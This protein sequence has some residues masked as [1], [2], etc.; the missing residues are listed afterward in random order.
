MMKRVL[1]GVAVVAVIVA[2]VFFLP[3][4][5]KPAQP[6][7]TEA[8]PEPPTVVPVSVAPIVRTTLHGYVETWGTVEPEPAF[9]RGPAASARVATAVAGIVARATCAEG[10][11]VSKGAVLFNLD[12]RVADVAV[13]RARAA[14]QFAEQVFARQQKLGAGEATSQKLYQ[15]A[16]QNVTA[17]R[18]ELATAQTQRALL[19]IQSPLAGTVVTVHAK[20]GDAVDP[21]TALAEIIDLDR[22]V[23]IA[24]VRSADLARVRRG[25]AV[26]LSTGSPAAALPPAP[27]P[28]ARSSTVAFIGAQVDSRTDTV[29]VR[30]AVPAGAGVRPGQFLAVRIAV[31]ER[32][33]RLAV[34]IESVVSEGGASVIAIVEGDTAVKRT[35]KVGLRD[36]DL[37]EVEGDG[38]KAGM[39]VVTAGAYGLPNDTRIRIIGR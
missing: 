1:A 36:G 31:D 13:A 10:D 30:M 35:V 5:L 6:A 14:V 23:V 20:P 11:R 8:G 17:A 9:E 22:L 34:P 4:W 3:H 29:P 33:D 38:L 25:Q 7:E 39:R 26:T 19:D 21:A 24:A 32:R 28:M 18:S 2:L 15:E 16:E 27:I 37:V 12:S